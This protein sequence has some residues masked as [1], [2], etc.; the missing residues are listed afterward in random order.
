MKTL[1][2]TL[3]LVF[4]HP[5]A[6]HS[7]ERPN[8]LWLVLEDTSPHFIGCYGNGDAKTPNMD[9]LAAQGIR[10]TR[11]FALPPFLPDTPAIRREFARVY[12]SIALADH[13]I[14]QLLGQL[15]KDGL[16]DDTI[17]FCSAEV[18]LY[19]LGKRGLSY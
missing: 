11:A 1:L 18:T 16:T 9:R 13:E 12:N 6:C 10:F 15:E 2:T 4:T 17:I 14:R 7:A 3:L 8:V 5:L 19:R